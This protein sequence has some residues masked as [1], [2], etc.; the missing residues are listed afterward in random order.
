MNIAKKYFPHALKADN[1]TGLLVAILFYVL[2]NFIGGF[3]FGLVSTLPLVGFIA[4]FAGWILGIY[5][6]IGALLSLLIFINAFR[7][8]SSSCKNNK[9]CT[10]LYRK[11]L[12]Q[13][14]PD[15]FPS[16]QRPVLC[17]SDRTWEDGLKRTVPAPEA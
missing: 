15:R 2:V 17:S 14:Q 8:N 13:E 5:C 16:N 7:R 6:G 9:H 4:S 12:L 1:V 3:V 11:L 10:T